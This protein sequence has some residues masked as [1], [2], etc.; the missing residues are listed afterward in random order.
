MGRSKFDP[1]TYIEWLD[2][3]T[4]ESRKLLAKVFSENPVTNY[5]ELITFSQRVMVEVLC[6][7]IAPCVADAAARWAEIM[8][9]AL[10]AKNTANGTPGEAYSD[11]LNALIA[12]Q[13][14]API[15]EASYTETK[16]I[17]LEAVGA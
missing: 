6:G 15:L 11:L 7:N 5:D 17:D 1:D 8:M 13:E 3:V 10:A 14:E 4:P 2:K 9:T 16:V 12:V